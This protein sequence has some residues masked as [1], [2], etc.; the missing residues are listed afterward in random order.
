[1]PVSVTIRGPVVAAPPPAPP[2]PPPPP[3]GVMTA[4]PPPM[5][6][7]PA[8]PPPAPPALPPPGLTPGRAGAWANARVETAEVISSPR[9]RRDRERADPAILWQRPRVGCMGAG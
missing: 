7:P 5:A 1:M 9:A 4:P 2:A 3:P 6:P 8:A